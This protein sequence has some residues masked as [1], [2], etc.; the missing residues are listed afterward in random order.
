[1]G[2]GYPR[3]YLGFWSTGQPSS[4]LMVHLIEHGVG[5][6]P[7]A[8][9]QHTH[10]HLGTVYSRVGAVGGA[11]LAD[12][13]LVWVLPDG[14]KGGIHLHPAGAA[15]HTLLP[16]LIVRACHALIRI[17]QGGGQ[18]RVGGEGPGSSAILML[19]SPCPCAHRSKAGLGAILWLALR[20]AG[21]AACAVG[22]LPDGAMGW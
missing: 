6:H 7:T 4:S 22:V 16:I 15:P 5:E 18:G 8:P 20:V 10:T 21:Q 3:W 17:L 19:V 14:H 12:P 1:M 11:E 9:P 2:G 13:L